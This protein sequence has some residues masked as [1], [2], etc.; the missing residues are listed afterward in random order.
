MIKAALPVRCAI[1][2]AA[3]KAAY[4]LQMI[5]GCG[6]AAPRMCV[7]VCARPLASRAYVDCCM[8][9]TMIFLSN[10]NL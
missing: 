1:A 5:P 7:F 6:A 4:V 2:V 3:G 10:A 9:N 8:Q